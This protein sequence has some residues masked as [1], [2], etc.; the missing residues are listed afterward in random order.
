MSPIKEPNYFSSEVRPENL[1]E[2]LQERGMQDLEAL[3][4][5]LRG[6]MSQ[7]RFGGMVL[8]WE[9]YLRLFQNVTGQKAIGEA[10][11]CYLWSKTAPRSIASRIPNARIIMILRDPAER[12]FSQY[13]HSITNGVVCESFR[14]HIQKSLRR[15][16][17]KFGLYHPFLELGLYYEQVKQYLELFPRR[18]ISILFFEDYQRRPVETLAGIFRFVNVDTSFVPDVSQ[19]QLEPRVARS[20]SIAYFLKRYGIWEHVKGPRAFRTRLGHIAF[21]KRNS[22]VMDVRD[23]QYLLDYYRDDIKKLSNLLDRDLSTWL[24]ADQNLPYA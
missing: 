12:A 1:S 15:K 17:E 11:V 10:S 24:N 14:R 7:K 23:R 22:L 16:S 20:I 9:D 13:L 18:N 19:K 4:E 3:K 21:K 5:Y 8:E 6:P 2:K